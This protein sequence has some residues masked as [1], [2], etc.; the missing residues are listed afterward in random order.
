MDGKI[1]LKTIDRDKI[2]DERL[3][4]IGITVLRFKNEDLYDI[5]KVLATIAESLE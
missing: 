1:H 3:N 4:E 5:K 2:R